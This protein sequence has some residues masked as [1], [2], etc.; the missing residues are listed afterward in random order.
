MD[1]R[2]NRHVEAILINTQNIIQVL[3]FEE[4]N[5]EFIRCVKVILIDAKRS[6][7]YLSH[8]EKSRYLALLTSIIV[9]LLFC[10]KRLDDIVKMPCFPH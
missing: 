5:I 10:V 2:R 7:Y 9:L 1:I 6:Q 8:I 3:V 4:P